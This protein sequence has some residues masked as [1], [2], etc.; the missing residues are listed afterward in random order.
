MLETN[1]RHKFR[2]VALD[3]M[4]TVKLMNRVETKFVFHAHLLPVLLSKIKNDYR[5]LEVASEILHR[6]ETLYYD[7]ENFDLYASHHAAHANRYKVRA[8]LYATSGQK[9]LE[10]KFKNN[11]N[12]TIK[13]RINIGIIS[14]DLAQDEPSSLFLKKHLNFN[15]HTLTPKFWVNYHR[16]TL[17]HLD[18]KERCTIDTG[19][20]FV[21]DQRICD[22]GFMVV[23]ELKQENTKASE[24]FSVLKEMG[25]R[26][27]GMSKYCLG[28]LSNYTSVKKNNFKLKLKKIDKIKNDENHM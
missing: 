21:Y 23:L 27:G 24:I 4:D 22:Y 6:Y 26:E 16:I 14:G 10:V 19:L 17:V 1:L 8:R 25:I 13:N 28:V 2:T 20:H 11:K 3:E 18:N 9:F 7:T 5:V 12:R 15:P